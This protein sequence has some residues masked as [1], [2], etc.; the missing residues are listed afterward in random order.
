MLFFYK[1]LSAF[2]LSIGGLLQFSLLI[3]Y[4][5]QEDKWGGWREFLLFDLLLLSTIA[6]AGLY[7]NY[8]WGT[9]MY[10]IIS[11]LLVG[12]MVYFGIDHW[13]FILL[14]MFMLFH[15]IGVFVYLRIIKN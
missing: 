5:Y 9:D 4:I 11:V 7:E 8:R 13:V 15:A 12:F 3:F 6:L 10:L 14:N 1:T 2:I